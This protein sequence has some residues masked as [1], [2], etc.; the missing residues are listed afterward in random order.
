MGAFVD[1][2]TR[3]CEAMREHGLTVALWSWDA[4]EW[5][6]TAPNT[7]RRWRCFA[8]PFHGEGD[9]GEEAMVNLIEA[10]GGAE[11]GAVHG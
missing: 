3:L 8:G 4:S 7:G 1:T 10:M 11:H 9:T 5:S 2:Q 6:P